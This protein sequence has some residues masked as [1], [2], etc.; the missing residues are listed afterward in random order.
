MLQDINQFLLRLTSFSVLVP[1]IKSVKAG[2][3]AE[4]PRAGSREGLVQA[5]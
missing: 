3:E 4:G 1:Y 5:V 2:V